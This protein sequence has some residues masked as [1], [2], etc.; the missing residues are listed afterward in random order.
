MDLILKSEAEIATDRGTRHGPLVDGDTTHFRLWAPS[1]PEVKLVLKEGGETLAMSRDEEGFWTLA[2]AGA[3]PGTRYKF[4]IGGTL[5]P[6]I[7]SRQQDAD[8]KGWSV[9]REPLP[10]SGRSAPLRPWHETVICEVH[11]GTATPEGTFAALAERLEHFRDA[12]YTCLEIMPINE[13]PGSRN[14]GY[15][16][17]LIFAPES[18]YGTPEELRA[19]VDRAH[20]LGLCMVLDVVYNHFGEVDNF[21][22]EVAP[23]FFTDEVET[24]WGP[25]VNFTEPAVRQFFYENA[26]MWLEEFDF[27]GLRFDAVH[28][29][30]TEGRDLFLIELAHQA[31]AAK[32]GA[33]LILENMDNTATWLERTAEDEPVLYAAQ[34]NDDI[35]HVLTHLV[36]G[37]PILGYEDTSKDAYADLEKA[38]ADGFVHDG[39]VE[40]H[41]D[42]RTRN[43]PASRLPPDAFITY[44]QNHDQIGNKGDSKRLA[45]HIAADKL[46]FL[47]FI[48]M[49][50]PQ[51]PLLF[52]GE[53]ASLRTKFPF[54]VD[55]PEEEGEE[56][57]RD[58]HEQMEEIFKEDVPPEGLPHPNEVDTF[59]MAKLDWEGFASPA[60]QGAL[61]RFRELAAM[62]REIVWPLA[63]SVC[64]DAR[65]VRQGNGIIITWVFEAGEYS[66]ALNPQEEPIILDCEVKGDPVSTGTYAI[67]GGTLQLGAWSAIVW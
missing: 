39:E 32:Q 24:P 40:G 48:V 62:R 64:T 36:T 57:H 34:W 1:A 11:I 10:P 51:I 29:M 33:K 25:A 60:A 7:A 27:D 14:W 15:D 47:Y 18:A 61:G 21:V 58:R 53:E 30:G 50:A 6:D 5:Y 20:E 67:G 44:V 23:E 9:V 13:F 42:G 66:M 55:F 56:K 43:E 17:T 46:D 12:G 4:E 37:E 31:M 2:V 26:R 16:G 35:H 65:S 19:L 38:L 49:L 45:D 3:G 22:A 52:M 41:S 63:A 8:T 59:K 28:E 54:F